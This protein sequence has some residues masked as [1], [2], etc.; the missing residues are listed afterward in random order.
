MLNAIAETHGWEHYSHRDYDAIV[1]KLYR[2]T[3]DKSILINFR[4]AEGL[5]ANF[6]HNL[7]IKESFDI[8]R[9]AMLVLIN[10]LKETLESK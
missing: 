5:H 9:E 6:Y 2:E 10:K 1:E 7:M 3:R 4:M 8:H